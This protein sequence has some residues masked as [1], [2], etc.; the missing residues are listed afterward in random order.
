MGIYHKTIHPDGSGSIQIN[1]KKAGLNPGE[2]FDAIVY[3]EQ[4]MF[5][6]MAFLTDVIQGT[7]GEISID[8]IHEISEVYDKD[9]DYVYTT[10]QASKSDL[11]YYFTFQPDKLLDVPFGALRIE[12]D[13]SATGSFTGIYC[14]F[15]NNET[16]AL[17]IIEEVEQMAELG[18]SYCEGGQSKINSKRF[19]YIF[20]YVENKEDNTPK[21]L[22]IKV[23]NG[24][25]ANG[26]FN[27]YIRKEPGVEIER[28]DF[29]EQK[30]MDKMKIPKCP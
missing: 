1:F 28:T 2:K 24:N 19:N 10:M 6:T 5:T 17:G 12:L 7:V 20:K 18:D 15:T 13:E 26:K 21:K 30:N 11:S 25:L 22:I 8:S 16:D 9:N 3:I 27:I 4:K 23:I 29:T 14:A